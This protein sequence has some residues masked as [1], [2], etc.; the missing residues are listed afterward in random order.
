[1]SD[2]IAD[3][4]TVIRNNYMARRQQCRGR[5]TKVTVGISRILKEE[6]YL[7]DYRETQDDRGHK[8]IEIN[9]KYVDETPAVT[10][11]ERVSRPGRRL[12]YKH[13]EI[14]RVLGGLG[15]GIVTTSQGVMNDRDAR[16]RKLG[17]EML[18][19]VW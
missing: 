4:L 2:T 16:K 13:D 9:L 19:R 10:G 15:V 17:G 11:I 7:R 3:F 8:F 18:A 12:Y 5:Y 1:M 6:G 14:P